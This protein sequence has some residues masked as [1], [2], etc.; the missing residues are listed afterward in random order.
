M[1]CDVEL[2]PIHGGSLRLFMVHAGAP[3]SARVGQMLAREK[4]DG[5]LSFDYYRDFSDR[6]ARLKEQLLALLRRLHGEGV[7]SPPM[8]RPPKAAR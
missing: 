3:P 1:I 5:L 7:A 6:V 8:A 4:S 2:V